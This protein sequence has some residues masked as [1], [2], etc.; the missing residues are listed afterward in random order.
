MTIGEHIK[1]ERLARGW[2][3]SELA[4]RSFSNTISI[5]YYENER[6][7]PSVLV[8]IGIADAFGISL[9]QLVGRKVA[10]GSAGT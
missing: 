4:R 5:S 8:L 6:S 10:D 9:D 7:L 2:T 1:Q 3:Q